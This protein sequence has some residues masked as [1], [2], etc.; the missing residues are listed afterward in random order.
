M[1]SVGVRLI[2]P[3]S[4]ATYNTALKLPKLADWR[5][6]WA[7]GV[8]LWPPTT[9]VVDRHFCLQCY[10]LRRI[11]LLIITKY[12]A[13]YHIAELYAHASIVSTYVGLERCVKYF[14]ENAKI[15]VVW[16]T[17]CFCAAAFMQRI[18]WCPLAMD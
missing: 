7:P 16:L 18:P 6:K 12:I 2:L 17:A 8:P 3:S 15:T 14:I 5:L 4:V 10:D 1:Y 11:I 9:V 13:Y